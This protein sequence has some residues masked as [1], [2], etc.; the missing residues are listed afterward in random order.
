VANF[1]VIQW[2]RTLATTDE[3]NA[4]DHQSRN[5]RREADRHGADSAGSTGEAL[6]ASAAKQGRFFCDPRAGRPIDLA[7][8]ADFDAAFELA[9]ANHGHRYQRATA[10]FTSKEPRN[11]K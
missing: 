8:G 10:T 11:E 4:E 1:L 2:P 3:E 7:P 5:H 9:A 6:S